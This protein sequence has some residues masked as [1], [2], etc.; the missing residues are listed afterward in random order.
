MFARQVRYT[1]CFVYLTVLPT[2]LIR[3][4]EKY[5]PFSTS[6]SRILV[7]W[8]RRHEKREVKHL[9]HEEYKFE[10]KSLTEKDNFWK[11]SSEDDFKIG[12]KKYYDTKSGGENENKT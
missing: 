8:Y 2:L 4:N 1:I 11:C 12:L 6:L 9:I 7:W 10:K 5:F 3:Q